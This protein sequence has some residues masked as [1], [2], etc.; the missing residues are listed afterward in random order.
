MREKSINECQREKC[1]D[2]EQAKHEAG[3]RQNMR[4]VVSEKR[5][6]LCMDCFLLGLEHGQSSADVFRL[7]TA[8]MDGSATWWSVPRVVGTGGAA[9]GRQVNGCGLRCRRVV[10]VVQRLD[11]MDGTR[12]G[13]GSIGYGRTLSQGWLGH[14]LR[15]WL[16]SRG[17]RVAP[18]RRN[19]TLCVVVPE[20]W[21]L[22]LASGNVERR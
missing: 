17:M 5:Q 4:R 20:G 22:H 8:Y 3:S 10:V 14:G 6:V 2:V 16:N 15:P 9:F 13:W 1:D 11:V 18:S 19:E 7:E 12:R 21:S